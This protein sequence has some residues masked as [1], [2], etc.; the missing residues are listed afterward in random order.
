MSTTANGVCA[1]SAGSCAMSIS[2]VGSKEPRFWCCVCAENGL[3]F[4]SLSAEEK[5]GD[6]AHLCRSGCLL[7]LEE[8]DI[9]EGE[10]LEE[11]EGD[12]DEEE[13]EDDEMAAWWQS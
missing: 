8:Q 11:E 1:S 2:P 7:V 6:C 13:D 12:E 10:I 3:V 9:E 4:V 5:C